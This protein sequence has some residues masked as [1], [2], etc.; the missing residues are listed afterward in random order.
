MKP[1]LFVG[2]DL[3]DSY[4]RTPR[5]V[6][7]A[8]LDAQTGQ[9][10]FDQFLWPT[11]GAGWACAVARI[12][13]MLGRT[14]KS[15]FIVDGPQALAGLQNN[16]RLAR[17]ILSQTHPIRRSSLEPE[18]MMVWLRSGP[19]ETPPISTPVWFSRNRR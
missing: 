19:V 18:R 16:T 4:A 12:V 17:P 13:S 11:Q 8:T 10:V 3:T 1:S 5:E 14:G 6:D 2:I 15:V 7:V 9:V